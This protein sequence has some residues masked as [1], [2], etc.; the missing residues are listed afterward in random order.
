MKQLLLVFSLFLSA[1]SMAGVKS[2][3]CVGAVPARASIGGISEVKVH[4][5]NFQGEWMNDVTAIVRF[6]NYRGT[7]VLSGRAKTLASDENYNPRV[8]HNHFRFDL[9][10]LTNTQDFSSFEPGDSCRI[11]LMI[12]FSSAHSNLFP[13]AAVIGCDQSGGSITLQCQLK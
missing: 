13:A 7:Q 5:V 6:E 9:S 11:A 3:V 10:R 4:S 8:Y 2:L 12:P 1:T